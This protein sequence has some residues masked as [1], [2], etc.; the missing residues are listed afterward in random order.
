MHHVDDLATLLAALHAGPAV[1]VGRS[2][3]G[4]IAVEFARHFPDKVK[5]LVL[6]E[7]ALFTL[8]PEAAAWAADARQRLLAQAAADPSMLA[9]RLLRDALGDDVW[10]SFP[11][12]LKSILMGTSPAVL[13]EM[14][15]TDWI[16]RRTRWC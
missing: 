16:F 10:E 2:T 4:Q 5:A 11:H 6:L 9:Q 14:R 13:A 3:G 12:E 7:P 15:A 8:D 1:V